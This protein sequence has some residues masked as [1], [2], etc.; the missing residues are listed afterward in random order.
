MESH[1]EEARSISPFSAG[2]QQA[3]LPLPTQLTQRSQ[4]KSPRSPK[5]CPNQSSQDEGKPAAGGDGCRRAGWS[6]VPGVNRL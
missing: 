4:T 6:L 2:S 1:G 5:K 3:I